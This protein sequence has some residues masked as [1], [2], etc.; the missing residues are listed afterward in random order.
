M[1]KRN[2]H[3]I[4]CC[5]HYCTYI[6]FPL[7]MIITIFISLLC[8]EHTNCVPYFLIMDLTPTLLVNAHDH[9]LVPVYNKYRTA[10]YMSILHCTALHY[11]CTLGRTNITWN[12]GC[13]RSYHSITAWQNSAVFLDPRHTS[14]VKVPRKRLGGKRG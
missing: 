8:N 2:V 6:H 10:I 4:V 11:T 13:T 5:V 3:A 14:T 12:L 1:S 7:C 9:I